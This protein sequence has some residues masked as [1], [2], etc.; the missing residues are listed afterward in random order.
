M[1]QAQEGLWFEDKNL[2]N[3][4]YNNFKKGCEVDK[5]IDH[6]WDLAKF[7]ANAMQLVISNVS[8]MY[9]SHGWCKFFAPNLHLFSVPMANQLC[10]RF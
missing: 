1:A 6:Q 7:D 9:S 3:Y 2:W 5:C 10:K 8:T 4:S